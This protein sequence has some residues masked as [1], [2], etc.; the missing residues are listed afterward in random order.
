LNMSPKHFRDAALAYVMLAACSPESTPPSDAGSIAPD[1]TAPDAG[2]AVDATT[3]AADASTDAAK[4]S[5]D[6]SDAS[7]DASDASSDAAEDVEVVCRWQSGDSGSYWVGMLDAGPQACVAWCCSSETY[8]S[9]PTGQT[10]YGCVSE[11]CCWAPPD[12]SMFCCSHVVQECNPFGGG[13]VPNSFDGWCCV[14]RGATDT[15]IVHCDNE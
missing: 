1:A 3:D 12:P 15:G 4:E 14:P 10:S 11:D 9:C 8:P 6:A 13:P 2:S 7:A 5:T